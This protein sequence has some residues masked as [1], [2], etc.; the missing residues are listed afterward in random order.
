IIAKDSVLGLKQVQ[1][2]IFNGQFSF[3]NL[4]LDKTEQQIN[5]H[6]KNIDLAQ[7]VALQQQPGIH[8]TGKI[9]G[10]MPLMIGEQG[11]RIEDGWL[12]SLE[13]GKLT[14]VDNPSFDA[15][16][17]QQPQL[18]L[19]ENLD[20]THLKSNV[21]FTPDG[22]L[23]FDFALQ[24]NNPDK[25]Q[26]VN[27]NYSHQ[28]NIFSLLESIRLVKSVENKIQQKLTQGDKK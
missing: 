25:K 7:I 1:G 10:D 20:F 4:W 16:K 19:L 26:A 14:I 17:V 9:E 2:E 22:W 27:F 18:A 15:I 28:E 11:I 13:G 8:I 5:M 12:S 23:F 6:F 24:G 3:G 21:K